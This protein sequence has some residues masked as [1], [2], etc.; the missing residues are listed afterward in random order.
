M[1][2]L[3]C[4]VELGQEA[5]CPM[6]LTW[7]PFAGLTL[8]ASR[9][10]LMARTCVFPAWTTG[11]AV[12]GRQSFQYPYACTARWRRGPVLRAV[13]VAGEPSRFAVSIRSGRSRSAA[14][15]FHAMGASR[16]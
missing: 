1:L 7:R 15:R 8:G 4:P 5:R 13:R 2:Q 14:G 16:L 3:D 12:T 6:G 11:A 9:P 10:I